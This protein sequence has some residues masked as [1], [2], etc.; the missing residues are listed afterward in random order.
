MPQIK[1]HISSSLHNENKR[2][3]TFAIREL[4]PVVL[5]IDSKIGQVLLYE[6]KYRASH[7]TRDRNFV[8][9]EITMYSGRSH[10]LK[11]NLLI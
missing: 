6:S 11:K 7:P 9:I 8:F 5:N 3:M 10:E 2:K 1:I 4:I